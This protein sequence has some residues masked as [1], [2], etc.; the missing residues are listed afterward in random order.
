[1]GK[2]INILDKAYLQWVKELTTRYRQSQIKAAVK[3]NSVLI[4]FYWGLGSDIVSLEVDNKYGGKFYATLSADLRKEM[5]GI[6]GLSESNI[7][8]AKRFYQLYAEYSR[9]LPQVVEEL[10]NIPWGHHRYIID[11]CSNNPNKALFYVRQTLE[12]GWSRAMLLNFLDTDLYERQGKALTNFQHTMPAVTSDLAQELT[13]DP[14]SF[15]FLSMRKG[16]NERQL[17]DALLM[18]VRI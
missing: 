14:Y 10:Y 4:E 11:K 1:M 16:Y 15:D 7:R 3:V 8:Y 9:I 12:Y 18:N 13:K 17:K 2:S 6:E 5:P